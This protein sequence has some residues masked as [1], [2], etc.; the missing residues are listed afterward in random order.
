MDNIIWAFETFQH[1][2]TFNNAIETFDDTLCN[3]NALNMR[4]L[5]TNNLSKFNA[6]KPIVN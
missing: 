1:K 2:T 6:T 3:T 4:T 5:L